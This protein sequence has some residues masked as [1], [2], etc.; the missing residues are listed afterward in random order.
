MFVF[1]FYTLWFQK[2]GFKNYFPKCFNKFLFF[3]APTASKRFQQN[4]SDQATR[5]KIRICVIFLS[6]TVHL[7]K[8][9]SKDRRKVEKVYLFVNLIKLISR[10]PK[11]SNFIGHSTGSFQGID[12]DKSEFEFS[13]EQFKAEAWRRRYI[14]KCR[15]IGY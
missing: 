8:F 1:K 5:T 7:V 13:I 14:S 9:A 11:C 4:K 3:R 2:Y 12:Q 10:I 6:L 15:S